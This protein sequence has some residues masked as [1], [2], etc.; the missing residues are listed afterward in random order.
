MK[1][2]VEE[3]M[4]FLNERS[5]DRTLISELKPILTRLASIARSE[6]WPLMETVESVPSAWKTVSGNGNLRHHA[7]SLSNS[8]PHAT[9]IADFAWEMTKGLLGKPQDGEGVLIAE[10]W[11]ETWRLLGC[12]LY[13][14]LWNAHKK[15][16]YTSFSDLWDCVEWSVHGVILSAVT[17]NR[18]KMEIFR[19]VVDAYAEGYLALGLQEDAPNTL[20]VLTA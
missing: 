18:E 10:V 4:S 11:G 14:S 17:G 12:H 20:I 8:P 7:V 15:S 3:L 9:E 6:E 5:V 13:T 19:G 16:G 2:N 1:K